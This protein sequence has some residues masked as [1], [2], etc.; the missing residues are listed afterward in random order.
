[1]NLKKNHGMILPMAH[2][3][4]QIAQACLDNASQHMFWSISE[5]HPDLVNCLHT[6]TRLMG[7]DGAI[8]FQCKVD[9]ETVMHFSLDCPNV[10]QQLTR[11]GL[12]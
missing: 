1:M 7:T 11:C 12:I 2:T 9:I 8:C 4:M 6:Q 10:W 5:Q 3:N